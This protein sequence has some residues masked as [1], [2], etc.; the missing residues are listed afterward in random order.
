MYSEVCGDKIGYIQF[1]LE[2]LKKMVM[3]KSIRIQYFWFFACLK[4]FVIKS[5]ITTLLFPFDIT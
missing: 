5:L 2:N 1:I 3:I 4:I